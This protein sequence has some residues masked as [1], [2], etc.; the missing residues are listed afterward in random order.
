MKLSVYRMQR[1]H[2]GH[3]AAIHRCK[4]CAVIPS[5]C[6]E[7]QWLAAS[8]VGVSDADYR[9]SDAVA[10]KGG[11]ALSSVYQVQPDSVDRMQDNRCIECL[12]PVYRMQRH[13]LSA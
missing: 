4:Q 9:T 12:E 3:G 11:R 7:H 6:V 13:T 8:I 2:A 1:G 5:D 10:R